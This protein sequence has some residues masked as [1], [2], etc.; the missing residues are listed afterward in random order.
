MDF[1]WLLGTN[2]YPAIGHIVV[3]FVTV[4]TPHFERSFLTFAH[5]Y[6]TGNRFYHLRVEL[7][8]DHLFV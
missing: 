2:D 3:N 6:A 4:V 7:K 8:Q 5:A 1:L